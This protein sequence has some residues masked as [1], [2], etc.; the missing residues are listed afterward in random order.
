MAACGY[1]ILAS[2]STP[3]VAVFGYGLEAVAVALGNVATLSARHRII[4]TEL[5]G[6]VNNLFRMCVLG[7]VPLGA[8]AGGLLST[9]FGLRTTFVVAGLVQLTLTALLGPRLSAQFARSP[10]AAS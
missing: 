10:A 3:V 9:Q 6:R 8:L 7:V 2:T 1:L 5:F 4:P